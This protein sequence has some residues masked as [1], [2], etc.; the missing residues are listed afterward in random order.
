ML[1]GFCCCRE[2]CGEVFG[3]LLTSLSESAESVDDSSVLGSTATA[4][5]ASIGSKLFVH[6][7]AKTTI[8]I[9]RYKLFIII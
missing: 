5:S 1:T 2:V 4:V 9:A 3:E 6:K 7:S 8:S